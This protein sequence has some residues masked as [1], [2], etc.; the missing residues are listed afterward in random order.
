LTAFA[1]RVSPSFAPQILITT[2]RPCVRGLSVCPRFALNR[3]T[4]LLQAPCES[5]HSPRISCVVFRAPHSVSLAATLRPL[6]VLGFFPTL[7][8]GLDPPFTFSRISGLS[9]SP[10]SPRFFADR[11]FRRF[12]RFPWTHALRP[13]TFLSVPATELNLA[14]LYFSP[15]LALLASIVFCPVFCRSTCPK[16]P[17][18]APVGVVAFFS[19]RGQYMWV[20]SMTTNAL[21]F[22]LRS[23][24]FEV[25]WS[26]PSRKFSC[27]IR[28]W[29]LQPFS[30]GISLPP[31]VFLRVLLLASAAFFFFFRGFSF[32]DGL[33]PFL[34][35][36]VFRLRRLRGFGLFLDFLLSPP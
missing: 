12:F 17:W 29:R 9:S 34:A 27:V 30:F 31:V 2:T 10:S 28:D 3:I 18:P 7:S 4:R 5:T 14:R 1:R 32:A 15:C 8:Q 35:R 6:I 22:V 36:T 16:L 24:A 33:F 11:S 23:F 20:P 13:H 19:F 25:S 21:D 26:S